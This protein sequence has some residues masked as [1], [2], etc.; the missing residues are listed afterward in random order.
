MFLTILIQIANTINL[1]KHIY[2]VTNKCVAIKGPH[3]PS[4]QLRTQNILDIPQ[5]AALP[6][7]SLT[8]EE[9]KQIRKSLYIQVWLYTKNIFGIKRSVTHPSVFLSRGR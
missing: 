1:C 6:C 5:R 3:I 8:R 4:L 7:I 2:H 9:G